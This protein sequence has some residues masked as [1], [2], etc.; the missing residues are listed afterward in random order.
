MV[1]RV[2]AE[3]M[4]CL[5]DVLQPA[6]I[7]LLQHP[8][9][10][11]AME[12]TARGLHTPTCLDRVLLGLGVHVALF[13]VPVGVFPAREIPAHFQIERDGNLCLGLGRASA[14]AEAAR[15]SRLVIAVPF[16]MV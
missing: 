3:R 7:R 4:P 8:A 9:D 5:G 16:P 13:V 14:S 1:V 6:H 2:I 11:K 12:R 15:N 10:N